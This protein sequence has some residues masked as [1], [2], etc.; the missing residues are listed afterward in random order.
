MEVNND[1]RE[2]G[3]R[4]TWVDVLRGFAL[5]GVTIANFNSYME[6]QVPENVLEGINGPWGMALTGINTVFLEWKFMTLFSIL[7]GYGFGLILRNLGQKGIAAGPFFVRRMAWLFVF[8]IIHALFW[9]GD[10]LHLYAISGLLLLPFRKLST[11][12]LAWAS[13]ICMFVLPTAVT[14]LFRGSPDHFGPA[15]L[16]GYYMALKQGGLTDVFRTN[17]QAYDLMFLRS[18]SD[19]HDIVETLGRFLLGYW[20]LRTGVWE[21]VTLKLGLFRK[22]TVALAVPAMAY[23]VV[24]YLAWKGRLDISSFLW[25]PFIKAGILSASGLYC[26]ILARIYLNRPDARVML[27]LRDMGRMTLTNYLL[28]SVVNIFLLY[29]I[30]LGQLGEWGQPVVWGCAILWL[31]AE[32]FGSRSWL[33][34]FRNGPMEWVWRQ[35]TYQRRLPLRIKSVSGRANL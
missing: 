13:A 22:M 18:G 21:N 2:P 10:V 12:Q 7:F 1:P 26:S 5:A 34:A 17:I 35:L 28:V 30:G 29:G 19:I 9:T 25:E 8:G 31:I 4:Q 14:F 24:R 6:Q 32:A 33:K 11:R 23:F 27:L 3:S 15:E 16:D 20:L